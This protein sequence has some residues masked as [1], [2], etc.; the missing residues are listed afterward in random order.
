[1]M[2]VG[3]GFLTPIFYEEPQY[4]LPPSPFPN[5]AQCPHPP[6]LFLLLFCFGLTCGTKLLSLGTVIPAAP[7]CVLYATGHQIY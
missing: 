7:C 4:C 5:F 2:I 6:A 3:R 1:M